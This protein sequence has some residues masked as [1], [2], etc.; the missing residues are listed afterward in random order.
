MKQVFKVIASC[1]ENILRTSTNTTS[2]GKDFRNAG[3][4]ERAETIAVEGEF[5]E[6]SCNRIGDERLALITDIDLTTKEIRFD[7]FVVGPA[8][9][10]RVDARI[11]REAI[12]R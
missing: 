10:R 3:G 1:G 4:F 7:V 6:S 9:V 8:E 5:R 12:R 2:L 11:D